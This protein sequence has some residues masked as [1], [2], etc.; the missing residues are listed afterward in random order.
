MSNAA[1]TKLTAFFST[2][3]KCEA[4]G[5]NFSVYKNRFKFAATA[6]GIADHLDKSS[7][8]PYALVTTVADEQA[9]NRA[10]T[11]GQAMIKQA[12]AST[13]PDALFLRVMNATSAGEMWE[14][15]TNEFEK[16]SKMVTVDLRR[17][18][19]DMRCAEN[20]DVRAHLSAMQTLRTDLVGMSAD[21]GNDNF[22]AIVMGSLPISYDPYLA[23]LT[24]TATVSNTILSPDDVIQALSQEYDRCALR[25]KSKK[26]DSDV[27]FAAGGRGNG[28]KKKSNV[29]CFNCGKK[30][31]IKADCWAPGGGKEGKGPKGRGGGKG[32]GKGK[33]DA[34]AA[35]EIGGVWMAQVEDDDRAWAAHAEQNVW[36]FRA[37]QDVF[38]NVETRNGAMG[39]GVASPWLSDYEDDADTDSGDIPELESV[40]DSS[41]GAES[42]NDGS[43]PELE[44]LSNATDGGSGAGDDAESSNVACACPAHESAARSVSGLPSHEDEIADSL[45]IVI[46]EWLDNIE[47]ENGPLTS[48]YPSAMLANED[49]PDDTMTE[50]Y[51]S[52]A[53]SHITP[54]RHRMLNYVSI[55]PRSITAADN[56]SFLAIGQGD[57]HVEIPNGKGVKTRILLR[58]VLY[59]PKI[60]LTLVS[61]SK[62]TDAGYAVLFRENFCKI[63]SG[64]QK[65]IGVINK[66]RGTYRVQSAFNWQTVTAAPAIEELVSI[67]DLHRRLGHV[68][69]D[70]AKRLVSEG[71]VTG[72]K[73]DPAST[74]ASCNSCSYAKMS[75]KAVAKERKAP[76]S[77]A[78]GQLIFSD[79]WGPS[80]VQ[81]INRREYYS[82]FTDDNTRWVR[83]YLQRT[84][85]Q[86]FDSYRAYEAWLWTQFGVKVKKLHSDR[87]GE[88]KSEE[89]NAHLAKNGT[90][91]GFMVHDTPEHNGVAERL[92]RTL[93][94]RVRAMLHASGLPK[95]LWGEAIVHAVYL[96][97][98]LSTSALDGKTPYEMVY[99]R[100]PSIA[101][102][103]EFGARV[104]VHDADGTKL[105]ARGREARWVGFDEVSSGHRVY[106]EGRRMVRVERSVKFAKDDGIVPFP[107]DLRI[108]GE[109]EDD[110]QPPTGISKP[111]THQQPPVTTSTSTPTPTALAP[112]PVTPKRPT[113][114]LR[115]TTS[116]PASPSIDKLRRQLAR[117]DP[118]GPDFEGETG[119]D[120]GGSED[121]PH[122]STRVPRPRVAGQMPMSGTDYLQRGRADDAPDTAAS[123]ELSDDWEMVDV[124]EHHLAA[125]VSTA[126]ALDP[127]WEEAR[128]RPDWPHWQAAINTELDSLKSAGTWT[129]VPRPSG[130]NVVDCK[131]VLRIKKNAAGEIEKYKARLVA[132]G[133]T[134]VQGVDYYETF[135]PTAKIASI[136]LVLA[137]AAR[138]DWDIDMFDFNSAYLNGELDT[139]EEIFMEQPPGHELADRA[140]HVLR[141]NKALYGLKQGGRKWYETLSRALGELGFTQCASDQAIFYAHDNGELTILAIHVDDCTI[142]SSSTTLL[143]SYKARI[144]LRF[145]MTDLGP[146]SWLLGIEIR[147]DREA[148]TISLSQ[149]SYIESI[150]QRFNFADSKPVAMPMDPNV[151]LS[152]E[153][154]AISVTDI[155]AMQRVPYREAVGSLMWAAIG[156]RPDI[157]FAVGLL[158]KFLDNPGTA[159]WEAVKRVFRYL[160]GTKELRLTYGA[161]KKGLEGYSDADGMSQEDRHAI[162]GYAFVIDGGAIS[163]SSKK[164]ELVTLSTTEAEYVALTH[165]AKEATWLRALIGELYRPLEH[166]LT[167]YGDN[168]SSIALA[169]SDIGQFH[170][171]TKHIDIRYHFIR[172]VLTNGTIRLV[173]CPTNDM[174]ADCLTKALPST[175]AK[176]FA[177]ALGLRAV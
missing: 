172:Y 24:A 48:S 139:D 144:G 106:F 170:A 17:K 97:N 148:R 143:R 5:T 71:H 105:D 10:W 174:V 59:A 171:R 41:D 74:I 173:Y 56:G 85:D 177:A 31:H 6:A 176:H 43:M 159:H 30:G 52:G 117:T 79:V 47:A 42:G 58:G 60:G 124:L 12:I 3:P 7:A 118:L 120:E 45:E 40:S 94:E 132:R 1:N 126:E 28:K 62:I 108:E 81:T 57:L 4:D 122:R 83:L 34:N 135:A 18:L 50:L 150:L 35:T 23:A 54:Y 130:R 153:H 145:K 113:T 88:Y 84:K 96:K 101:G 155:A 162:S 2:L 160:V 165:A 161:G 152:N 32:K 33:E 90:E 25:S 103:P 70:A 109:D 55:P 131:W 22:I 87:G 20:G 39:D 125:A 147:R 156:T 67:E 77:T 44:S 68:A 76:R 129:V 112:V 95:Y 127:S 21:P 151:H 37:E 111:T 168:Q 104:W 98:R 92:N 89:F 19:Q 163:W 63:F 72:V 100:K 66:T 114:L 16:K 137:I 134:Q 64:R 157:A 136:R 138:N 142:T 13:I 121:G 154:R 51:D 49:A 82:S 14:K 9:A 123:A 115:L 116:R 26:N 36:L 65:L 107:V 149:R 86:T 80:P 73:I 93:L 91:R 38:G 15:V 53:S 169:Y 102:L 140:T 75:R 158:S 175:K 110:N 69:P 78:M 8:M 133:F 27:A 29:E 46:S 146:V 166:P 119:T 164:Q 128:R 11:A 99:N 167:L 61:V 141:L